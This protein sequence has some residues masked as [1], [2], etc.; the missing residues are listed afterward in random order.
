M[1]NVIFMSNVILRYLYHTIQSNSKL[2]HANLGI[3]QSITKKDTNT[4]AEALHYTLIILERRMTNCNCKLA[5][6]FRT[7]TYFTSDKLLSSYKAQLRSALR[8]LHT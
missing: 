1:S 6:L 8:G 2:V 7:K 5:F 4:K 3:S